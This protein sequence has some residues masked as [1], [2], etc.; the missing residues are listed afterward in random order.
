MD[1]NRDIEF[2]CAEYM[3]DIMLE[4]KFNEAVY[5]DICDY[6]RSLDLDPVITAAL[7]DAIGEVLLG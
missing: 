1:N 7:V 4:I 6:I 5:A 2:E 3:K